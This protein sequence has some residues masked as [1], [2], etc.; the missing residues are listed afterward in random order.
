[1][2][3]LIVELTG[4]EK[5]KDETSNKFI[6]YC[7]NSYKKLYF[8]KKTY[9]LRNYTYPV[10]IRITKDNNNVNNLTIQVNNKTVNFIVN[11]IM[12]LEQRKN[13]IETKEINKN[14]IISICENNISDAEFKKYLLD[15]NLI[16]KNYLD[17]CKIKIATG[18]DDYD[19]SLILEE[20][21]WNLSNTEF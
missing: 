19:L 5:Y 16:P 1:M 15:N 11:S 7:R 21:I 20:F 2:P 4:V 10:Q 12:S 18:K 9:N 17:D 8:Q 13:Y 6:E 3:F 14:V